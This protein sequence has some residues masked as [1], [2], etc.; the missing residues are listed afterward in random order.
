M[1]SEVID[2]YINKGKSIS[3]IKKA[4]N[5]PVSAIRECLSKNRY[6]TKGRSKANAIKMK[7]A[8]DYYEANPTTTLANV[9]RIFGVHPDN[10]SNGI[11]QCGLQVDDRHHLPLFNENVFDIIDT[12]EKAYWLGFIFADGYIQTPSASHFRY[13]FELVV[14]KSDIGHLNKFNKFMQHIKDNIKFAHYTRNNKVYERC[15]WIVANKNL[16]NKLNGY[17]CTPNKSLTLKFPNESIFADK[18]LIR[19]FIRGYFEGDGSLGIYK[20]GTRTVDSCSMV[21]T[22]EFLEVLNNYLPIKGRLR[23]QKRHSILTNELMMTSKI[24]RMVV[25]YLYENA[26]IYLDRKYKIYEEM[27]RRHEKLC[28]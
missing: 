7:K 14:Q 9:G 2:L 3:D 27:C 12:E 5:I 24:A 4:L 25:M 22:K 13:T 17:G 6:L 26:T 19:H 11:K 18:S 28:R 21:G 1:E 20:V 10:L 8:I 15:R 16:W 23:H